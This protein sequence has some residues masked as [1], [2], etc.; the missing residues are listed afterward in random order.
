MLS[1]NLFPVMLTAVS[2]VAAA[3][4]ASAQQPSVSDPILRVETGMHTAAIKRAAV[5]AVGQLLATASL[6][7][8]VRL[9]S[10]V[11]G[12]LIRI[13][14]PPIADGNEGKLYAVAI[15]P[16]GEWVVTGGTTGYKWEKSD[17]IYVFDR[18]SGSMVRRITGLPGAVEN[19]AWSA[20]GR[21]VAAAMLG[22]NGISVFRTDDWQETARDTDYADGSYGIAFDRS[23][24]LAVGS[25]DGYIRL[26]TSG[27]ER[28]A[29]VKTL[30]GEHPRSVAFSP[31]D[32]RLAVGYADRNGID[33]LSA[34]DLSKLSSVTTGGMGSGYS[35]GAVAWAQDGA[36]LA[37]GTYSKRDGNHPIFRWPEVGADTPQE[38]TAARDTVLSIIPLPDGGFVYAS[39]DPAFGRYDADQQRKIERLSEIGDFRKQQDKIRLSPDASVIGYGLEQFGRRPSSFAINDRRLELGEARGDLARAETQDLPIT[40]WQGKYDP[41]LANTPLKVGKSERSRSLAIAPDRQSFLLGL[42]FSFRRFDASGHQIWARSGPTVA[43]AVNIS[44]DGRLA[45][46]AFGDGT[47]RWYRYSDGHE[48]LALFVDKDGKRWVLW[49]PEGYYDASPGAE[50]LIGWQVNRGPAHEADFFPA[51]R[52]RERFYKPEVISAVLRTL[53]IA[54]ALKQMGAEPTTPITAEALPPVIKIL[55]PQEGTAI[56]GSPVPVRY[57]VRSP[58]GE[59]VTAIEVKLDGRPLPGGQGVV[60]LGDGP[61]SLETT[62]EGTLSVP[63]EKD[64][65]ITLV[66][67][68]GERSSEAASLRVTWK[69]LTAAAPAAVPKPKLYLLAVGVSRYKDPNLKLNYSAKDAGDVAAAWAQQQG[70]LYSEVVTR[71]LRDEQATREAV[72]DGLDWIER[73]TTSRDVALVL[74]SGHGDND[75]DG[76]YYFL[77]YDVDPDRLRRSAVPDIEIRRSLSHV[78]GKALFFFDTCHSGSVISGR[79]AAQTDINGFV[80]E[81]ASAENGLVVFAAS[82][83]REFAQERDEWKNGAFSKALIEGLSGKADISGQGIITVNALEYWLGERVKTLTNG[84]QHPTTAK[85]ETIRD[86]PIAVTHAH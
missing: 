1:K 27:F 48:L 46:A 77:P 14:R 61:P 30:G 47:I 80:S 18:A 17:S 5:D 33:I 20:D 52:F 85:P 64:A 59:R 68:A 24:R 8:T 55:S 23:G 22:K 56:A 63:I 15:S 45:V 58:S 10:L 19:L 62:Q 70:G 78:S 60:R 71:I 9:W 54:A 67:R 7:K 40:D 76:A 38:L 44:R 84:Q 73:E 37:G 69:P 81:L 34:N 39:A 75:A 16:N 51:S 3:F 72:L 4:S 83:G 53:D 12:D 13:L 86:F 6:D 29:K 25:D 21:F 50:D 79:K 36:L 31:D 43:W 28:I 35:F 2:L 11:T 42:E 32:T 41:K 74:L 57:S 66:A 65:T 26:Y 49:T 82:T